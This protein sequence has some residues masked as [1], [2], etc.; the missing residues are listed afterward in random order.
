M[1]F[2]KLSDGPITMVVGGVRMQE[3]KFGMQF[4][5]SEAGGITEVGVSENA[6]SRALAY[7][8]LTAETA[9][10][11]T[12]KFEQVKKDGKT[13]TNIHMAREGDASA[14]PAPVRAASAASGG[15]LSREEAAELYVW[16][17][18]HANET[19]GKLCALDNIPLD[20]SALQ[21]AAAT[22]FIAVKGR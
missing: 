2:A 15:A 20:A 1:A 17:L 22:L 5:F 8:N 21:S 4:V 3:S 16:A 13:Y 6:G 9:V 14:A 18:N 10:G 19:L 12:L 11:K 7:L